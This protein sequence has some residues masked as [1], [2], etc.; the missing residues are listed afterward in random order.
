MKAEP[1]RMA[2]CGISAVASNFEIR[3]GVNGPDLL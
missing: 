1:S 2:N 3:Q